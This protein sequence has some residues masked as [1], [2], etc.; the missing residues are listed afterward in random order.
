MFFYFK[1]NVYYNL[2]A[3]DLCS[4][5]C[6]KY[7]SF[8]LI[9]FV[10]CNHIA[11]AILRK[12]MSECKFCYVCFVTVSCD[13]QILH[14][15]ICMQK[16]SSWTITCSSWSSSIPKVGVTKNRHLHSCCIN[17]IKL[18]WIFTITDKCDNKHGNHT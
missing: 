6:Y 9:H 3:T 10:W 7:R 14:G 16:L 8:K 4:E 17:V 12:L 15:M 1:R 2:I 5:D 11:V 18:M 13:L